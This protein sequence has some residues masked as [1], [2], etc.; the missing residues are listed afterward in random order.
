MIRFRLHAASLLAAVSALCLAASAAAEPAPASAGLGEWGAFGVQTKWIDKAAKP[1]DDFDAWVNGV[2][3][4]TAEMPADKTRISSFSELSDL[5]EDRIKGILEALARGTNAPASDEA[6][7]AATYKAFM[8]TQAIEAAGMA[9]ARPYLD[10]IWAAKSPTDLADLFASP[11]FASPVDF[12]IMA[13]MKQSDVYALYMSA[14]GLGL[15][16]RD[17]YLEDTETFREAREKYKE[18]LAFLLGKAGYA[19]PAAAAQS[20]FALEK[21]LARQQWDRALR[22]QRELAYNKV[23]LAQVE[24]Y[25]SPG[26]VQ[27]L[28]KDVPTR[29]ETVI[30]YDLPPTSDELAGAGISAAEAAAKIGGGTP[31]AF[32]LIDEAPLA[33]WQAY[34]VAHFLSD[35]AAVL[36]ADIDAATFAF[37]GKTLRGQ[38]EQRP[39]WKRGIDVVEDTVGDLLGKVY[40]ARY[41]PPKERAAMAELVANLRTAMKAN[42]GGLA[43]MSPATRKEATAKLDAFTPKIGAPEAYK[44]YAGLE[45]SPEDPLGN[46]MAATRWAINFQTV[47]IG[48]TVDRSEW[49]IYPQ[50]VNAYYSPTMNEIVFPAAILQPPFFN[51]SADPAVNYGAIG[52]VIGHE[53]GH[54]FDDQ[55]S[56]S[57][58]KGN[59]RDWWTSQDKANFVRL[60]KKLGAQFATYCPFDEGKTCI[61]PE[62]TMGENIGDLGGLS[63]A[64]RAYKLSLGGKPAAVIDGFTGD[65]RFFL[66]YAQIWRGQIRDKQAREF[67]ATDPHSP[68]KYRVNGVV[69]N[70]DEWYK[71]F[72]V[73]PGD[74]LYLPPAQR[75]RI[76]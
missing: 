62:L 5:S 3:Y 76:W 71:A 26:I 75:V 73:K 51:P 2:W 14:G 13:D 32:K 41:Y 49:N 18:Y 74:A 33:T 12:T 52:A 11:G 38:M 35:H 47:R 45:V 31:S 57:D 24:G 17:Y 55:G 43:W 44:D 63:L 40:A 30:V 68:T 29:P 50:T 21:R 64:Y 67:L 28:L 65:Q 9:P 7:I 22:R 56:K 42:L 69:R 1:G 54:G 37:Y 48:K 66:A 27:T 36:P 23:P 19:D 10:R 53:I 34:L 39:R 20:V 8:D 25:A 60:Q 6:R 72:G 46:M 15:P 58:G 70:F 61:N 4:R 59:L 16:D